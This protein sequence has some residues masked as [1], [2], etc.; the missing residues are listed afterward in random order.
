MKLDFLAG[1]GMHG[2]REMFEYFIN[3][4][5]F[6][7]AGKTPPETWDELRTTAIELTVYDQGGRIKT[8]G[9]ALPRIAVHAGGPSPGQETR[10]REAAAG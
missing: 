7:A 5:I 10:R 2:I 1:P 9:A 4:E 6:E 3:S 8:A